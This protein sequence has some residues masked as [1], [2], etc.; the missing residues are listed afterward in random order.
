MAHGQY[1]LVHW[2]IDFGHGL[3][4]VTYLLQQL[5]RIYVV[6]CFN[7]EYID[8]DIGLGRYRTIRSILRKGQRGYP[9]L[10]Q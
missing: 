3:R 2:P 10:L 8:F 5:P 6:E 7:L 1:F 9:V 4:M